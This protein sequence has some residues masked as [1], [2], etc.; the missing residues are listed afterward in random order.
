MKEEKLKESF[1]LKAISY[2]LLPLFI[3]AIIFSGIIL[4][5]CAEYPEARSSRKD[6][7][8]TDIFAQIYEDRI[9]PIISGINTI[10]NTKNYY[11]AYSSNYSETDLVL[12]N[13][14]EAYTNGEEK[15]Y[16]SARF[17][18]TKI[19]YLIVNKDTN[20]Y[21]T[22]LD[23]T[24]KTDSI[25]KIKEDIL[26]KDTY[27]WSIE[28]KKI[29]TNIEKL[30]ENNTIYQNIGNSNYDIYTSYY[31]NNTE[32][33]LNDD[34]STAKFL[35]KFSVKYYKICN[36][37]LAISILGA[38]VTFMYLIISAGHK[39]DYDGIY[40]GWIDELPLEVLGIFIFI[41]ASVGILVTYASAMLMEYVFDT[42][43]MLTILTTYITGIA[44]M[45]LGLS[46]VKRVKVGQLIKNSILWRVC[47]FIK[48]I[49]SKIV[50][51]LT[52]NTKLS[53]RITIYCI[54][55]LAISFILIAMNGVG[56]IFLIGFWIY[57]YLW[58]L[59]K[60]NEMTKIQKALKSIYEGNIN[61][62]LNEKELSGVLKEMA[63]YVNDIAGGFSNAVEASIKSERMKTE[64]ITNVSHDIK[65]PLTS[66]INYVDL[67]KKENIK[68]EKAKEYL[69]VLEVKSQ[70]L[71]KLI[72]DLI[73]ASKASSGNIKLE[74]Q[75]INI[76]ELIKQVTG[77]F[78]DKFNNKNLEVIVDYLKEDVKILAD[79]RYI[80]RIIENLYSN[81]SKYALE[82]SRVYVDIKKDDNKVNIAIKNISKERLNI[83][84][85]ELMQRFVRGDSSRNTEGSGLGLSI[86]TSLT[87]LQGGKFNIYLDGDLFK[88]VLEFEVSK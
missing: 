36:I 80:Y 83:S 29:N 40:L 86:A 47:R 38:F 30:V 35:Y 43:I 1:I 22:N 57:T 48:R 39:K 62:N 10:T 14:Q 52:D 11:N 3:I 88:V 5:Y 6:F 79:N 34:I 46:V 21:F 84:E 50:H 81:I 65:T 2:I 9:Y 74:K 32:I 60:A 7:Y 59:G 19:K 8:N 24:T 68:N 23:R 12:N 72:E 75:L 73:E 17:Q 20:E 77:E 64:L 45:Y 26:S 76:N 61:I 69:E 53:T 25:E 44:L 55:F 31:A 16:Y 66:I 51:S 4:A 18:A 27:F 87:E 78:E 49:C 41:V 42:G 58:I 33:T 85:E 56:I 15:I 37:L 67:L 70:R 71:K 63:I 82:N 28:N 54:A 13:E